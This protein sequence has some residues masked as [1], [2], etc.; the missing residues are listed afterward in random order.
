[1]ILAWLVLTAVAHGLVYIWRDFEEWDRRT[2]EMGRQLR[3]EILRAQ[4]GRLPPKAPP[5]RRRDLPAPT[6][7]PGGGVPRSG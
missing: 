3:E 6:L 2:E 7:I 1:M 5:R 4:A